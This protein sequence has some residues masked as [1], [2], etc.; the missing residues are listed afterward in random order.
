MEIAQ[1][2]YRRYYDRTLE[3]I[4]R[5]Q[6]NAV[7][8]VN[9]YAGM[10]DLSPEDCRKFIYQ[11]MLHD[12][13]KFGEVQFKPYVHLTDYYYRKK[14]NK[15]HKYPSPEIEVE[16]AAAVLDHYD[17]E[18]HHPEKFRNG[19]G[20]WDKFQALE[21]ACDLQAMADEFNEGTFEKY[22]TQVWKPK[23]MQHFYDDYN[24]FEVLGYL[25]MALLC[26]KNRAGVK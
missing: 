25:D 14:F 23:Q 8:I 1:D 11:V 13:S 26:F 9:N 19:I 24:W 22:F 5:V 12:R 20:K 18:N 17:V 4:H 15:D 2:Q 10:F 21:C 7:Y 6:K 16:V 3:H